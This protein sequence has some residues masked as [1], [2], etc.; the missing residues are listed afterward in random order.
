[1]NLTIRH[2]ESLLILFVYFTADEKYNAQVVA[3][4]SDVTR[5]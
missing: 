5:E 3:L 1:M 4:Q 2:I